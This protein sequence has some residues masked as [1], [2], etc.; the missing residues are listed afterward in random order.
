MRFC[1]G[2]FI[3]SFGELYATILLYK[4]LSGYLIEN[5]F[6]RFFCERKMEGKGSVVTGNN[7]YS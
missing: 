3:L 7:S 6:G 2:I 5:A 4:M 1:E